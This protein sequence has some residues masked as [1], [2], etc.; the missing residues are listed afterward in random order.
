MAKR[1]RILLTQ[2]RGRL[3]P[4]EL[5]EG[6]KLA[7]EN[8]RR[9]IFDAKLLYGAR[10]FATA[11]ALSIL[12]IE[13]L[14]KQPI[15]DCMAYANDDELEA[16]WRR[17]RSHSAKNVRWILPAAADQGLGSLEDLA[18]LFNPQSPHAIFADELK[19]IY[20]YTDCREDRS[21]S[22]P[23][24]ATPEM[25]KFLLDATERLANVPP[26]TSKR[27]A[28]GAKHFSGLPKGDLAVWKAALFSYMREAEQ[29]GI[30]ALSEE[31]IERLFAGKA[32]LRGLGK[33]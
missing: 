19:Q 11:A 29:L 18:A 2:Y 3:T 23:E 30:P 9:L 13:E 24:D 31:S 26:M 7:L 28:L 17:Y 1:E 25:A 5:A 21:W 27:I 10:R 14:G 33:P 20:L 15:L 12:A 32:D 4:E 8:A 22:V 6:A 16:H